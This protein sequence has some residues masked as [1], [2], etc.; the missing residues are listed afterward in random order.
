M[1]LYRILPIL[2]LFLSVSASEIELNAALELALKN[3][4]SIA[5]AKNQ[6]QIAENTRGTAS[7]PLLPTLDAVG[8]YT[9]TNRHATQNPP[10][11]ALPNGTTTSNAFNAQLALSWTIFDGMRMF[12][13]R[14]QVNSQADYNTQVAQTQIENTIVQVMTSYWQLLAQQQALTVAQKQ[15]EIT[16]QRLAVQQERRALGLLDS[17]AILKIRVDLNADSARLLA[18]ELLLQT[19]QN[20]L[21]TAIGRSYDAPI[22]AVS[23]WNLPQ[24]IGSVAD[25]QAAATTHNRNFKQLQL[26]LQMAE[27]NQSIKGSTLWPTISLSGTYGYSDTYSNLPNNTKQD[28]NAWQGQVGVNAR[29][30]IFNGLQ[31]KIARQNQA[32]E[33]QNAQSEIKLQEL[34]LA[35][36]VLAQHQQTLQLLSQ[37]HFEQQAL[38]LAQQSFNISAEQHKIGQ[39]SS[40]EFRESQAQLLAAELRIMQAQL[41]AKKALIELERLCGKIQ[42]N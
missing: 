8:G 2:A 30:N 18:Q 36:A 10:P 28:L 26:K 4:F 12:H 27:L 42:I 24:D 15:L 17:N 34:T 5:I 9:Y 22:T 39:L 21:N 32:L 20:Q 19:V 16:M 7:S 37:V 29:W 13:T 1:K 33:V 41:S 23:P 11:V 40:L 6:V 35:N 25:W 38:E 3:H 14:A 31:D